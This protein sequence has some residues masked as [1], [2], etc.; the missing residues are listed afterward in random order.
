MNSRAFRRLAGVGLGVVAG[1]SSF[2]FGIFGNTGLANGFRWDAAA[3]TA[4]GL[5]RSLDGGLRF[6]LQGGDYQAY[7][8]IFTWSG[9]APT[10]GAFQTA[11][12][13]A[14]NAWKVVDPAS[15]LGTTLNFVSDFTTPVSMTVTSGV[16]LGAEIDLFGATSAGSWAPNDPGLRAEAGFHAVGAGPGGMTLTSGTTGYGGAAISGADI[17]MNSNTQAQWTLGWFQTILTHEIGHAIGFADVDATS[18]PTGTFIDDNYDGTSNATAAATLT[19]SFASLINPLNPAASP[20][21]SYFVTNGTPGFDSASA[22]ILMETAIDPFFLG[23]PNMLRND[24]FAGRQ[25]LYPILPV[26]EPAT[27]A[28]LGLGALAV[29]RRRKKA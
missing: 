27:M 23:N 5:E 14:F 8:D 22:H 2:G 18:G 28:I 24:D 25:F 16:R 9:G 4:G 7:R 6:S 3:R 15:G 1:S 10:V 26:P 29:L 19:N 13:S 17:I 20:L 12:E 21:N 11:V